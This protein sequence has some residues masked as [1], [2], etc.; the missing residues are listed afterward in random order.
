[1]NNDHVIKQLRYLER[2]LGEAPRNEDGYIVLG[3]ETETDM[4][5]SL[6][7]ALESLTGKP[8]N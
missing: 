6:G 1:M 5:D 8:R 3:G 4:K 2:L 7:Q